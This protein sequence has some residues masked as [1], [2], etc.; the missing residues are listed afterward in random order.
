LFGTFREAEEF[1]AQCGF[2]ANHEQ[3]LAAMLLFRDRY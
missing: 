1:A 2:P 3:Q